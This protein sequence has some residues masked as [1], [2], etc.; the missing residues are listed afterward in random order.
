MKIRSGVEEEKNKEFTIQNEVLWHGT[1]L[2]APNI[3][4]LKKELLKE[5][6]NSTLAIHPGGMKMYHDLKTH[7]WWNGMKRDNAD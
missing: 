6:H 4:A 3:T 2:C 5:A 7:Y 1:R